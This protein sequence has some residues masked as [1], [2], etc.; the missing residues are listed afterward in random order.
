MDTKETIQIVIG[1]CRL[2]RLI[3][4]SRVRR[5]TTREVNATPVIG[6]NFEPTLR[7]REPAIDHFAHGKAALPKPKSERLLFAAI[8]GVALHAN[9]HAMTRLLSVTITRLE[10]WMFSGNA[11]STTAI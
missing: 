7:W 9:C 1:K 5:R 11:I 8:A 3:I 4:A 10:Y 6:I 2:H